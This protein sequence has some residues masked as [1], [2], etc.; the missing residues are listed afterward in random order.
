MTTKREI[1]IT[2]RTDAGL[3]QREFADMLGISQPWLARIESGSKQCP[4]E[5]FDR[6]IAELDAY[7]A[8]PSEEQRQRDLDCMRAIIERNN[9]EGWPGL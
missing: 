1:L 9:E 6:A 7:T 5:L 3:T 4:Q 8:I 2:R